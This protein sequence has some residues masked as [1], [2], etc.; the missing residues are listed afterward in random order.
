MVVA[1]DTIVLIVYFL[2]NATIRSSQNLSLRRQ[3]GTVVRKWCMGKIFILQG[4]RERLFEFKG[5]RMSLRK[6]I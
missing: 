6:R 4:V 3:D 5:E 2:W 1:E